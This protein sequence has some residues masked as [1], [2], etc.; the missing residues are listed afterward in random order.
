M[1]KF[2]PSRGF[3]E[4]STFRNC[5]E[6][7]FLLSWTLSVHVIV[8]V[9]PRD[10]LEATSMLLAVGSWFVLFASWNY[11]YDMDTQCPR[12]QKCFFGAVPEGGPLQ[13]PTRWNKFCH[14]A[15]GSGLLLLDE[16]GCS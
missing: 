16:P 3:L 13:K 10:R 1:T 8:I 14:L 12:E 15:R 2:V 4:R 7:T 11:D 9:P 6:K 5:T